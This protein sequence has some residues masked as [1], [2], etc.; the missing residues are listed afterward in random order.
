MRCC[1]VE[2]LI[3]TGAKLEARDKKGLRP[4][5]SASWFAGTVV[6]DVILKAGADIEARSENGM[7]P[8]HFAAKEDNKLILKALLE[9]GADPTAQTD[10]GEFAFDLISETSTLNGTDVY[11]QL[12][13]AR[14][15]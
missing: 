6:V 13:Q 9:A 4:L 11:W 1:V 3:K 5:H 7:R 2:T 8:L 14:F 10:D 12:S 15:D